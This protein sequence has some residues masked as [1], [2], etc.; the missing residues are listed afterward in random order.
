MTTSIFFIIIVTKSLL[1]PCLQIYL[2][3]ELESQLLEEELLNYGEANKGFMLV[4]VGSI[5]VLWFVIG[6]AMYPR[7]GLAV[8][9]PN[10]NVLL[11]FSLVMERN[12][13]VV[14]PIWV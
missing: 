14:F 10:F 8:V 11:W 1:S 13:L 6:D 4:T 7:M 12:Y 3:C 9:D 2:T 5:Q